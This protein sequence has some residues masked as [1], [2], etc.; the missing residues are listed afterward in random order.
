MA[1][2]TQALAGW[3]VVSPY[4]RPFLQRTDLQ[5]LA[6]RIREALPDLTP[7]HLDRLVACYRAMADFFNWRTGLCYPCH[8]TIGRRMLK[9]RAAQRR[10]QAKGFSRETVR[11]DIKT[12]E[13]AGLIMS[14]NRG[15]NRSCLY[16]FVGF[17][18]WLIDEGLAIARTVKGALHAWWKLKLGTNARR[19]IDLSLGSEQFCLFPID[20]PKRTPTPPREFVQS[21]RPDR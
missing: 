15:A 6:N 18:E 16:A 8:E 21:R 9:Y 1:T 5:H 11:L 20:P 4:S 2:V 14:I 13:S 3:P 7:S 19:G 12:L 10:D 17:V